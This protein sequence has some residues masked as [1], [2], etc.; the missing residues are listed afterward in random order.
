MR[1]TAD[2][3]LIRISPASPKREQSGLERQDGRQTFGLEAHM[4]LTCAPIRMS[5]ANSVSLLVQR[6]MQ[7]D[8][9]WKTGVTTLIVGDIRFTLPLSISPD[10]R[11]QAES[12]IDFTRRTWAFEE[13]FFQMAI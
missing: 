3:S 12:L 11:Q 7:G 5:V 2:L 6:G 4:L 13:H 9:I 8:P 1:Q 10:W